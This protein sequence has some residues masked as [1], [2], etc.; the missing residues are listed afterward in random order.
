MSQK[1]G[2]AI[3]SNSSFVIS[4]FVAIENRLDPEDFMADYPSMVIGYN[5]YSQ[6]A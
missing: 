2:R 3:R 1:S 5:I 4:L 6:S